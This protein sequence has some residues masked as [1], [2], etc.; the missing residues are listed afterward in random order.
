MTLIGQC[1][2]Q[3]V[4]IEETITTPTMLLIFTTHSR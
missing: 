4:E 3:G 1:E 2:R